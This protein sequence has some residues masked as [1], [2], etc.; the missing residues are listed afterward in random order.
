MTT[1]L[2]EK[3]IKDAEATA[4]KIAAGAQ[5]EVSAIERET[6][7]E[8]AALRDVHTARLEKEKAHRER[9]ALSKARQAG[10]IAVQQA[11][12][13]A[14][15]AVFAEAARSIAAA[16]KSE[17][18][19]FFTALGQSL[20]PNDLGAATVR[21]PQHRETETAEIATALG[22]TPTFVAAPIQAGLMVETDSGVYDVTL[23]RLLNERRAD[24]EVE[25]LRSITA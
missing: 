11:K 21:G 24:L 15:D 19:A 13:D 7:G 9:V 10:K 6:E 25:I 8:L 17:Y 20:V 3:I 4:A 1:T 5:A 22:L 16:E 2:T 23:E 18:V 12:R 14:I